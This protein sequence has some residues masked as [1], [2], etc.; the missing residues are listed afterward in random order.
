[1]CLDRKLKISWSKNGFIAYSDLTPTSNL[2]ITK[3]ESI[4]GSSWRLS[5]KK[6]YQIKTNPLSSLNPITNVYWSTS[7]MDLAII[8]DLGNLTIL[9]TGVLKTNSSHQLSCFEDVDIIYQDDVCERPLNT[10]QPKLLNSSQNGG[11]STTKVISFKWLNVDKPIISNSPA[12]R[13]HTTQESMVSSGAAADGAAASSDSSGYAYSYAVHQYKSYG[14]LHPIQGKSGFFAVRRNGEVDFYYQATVQGS[15]F[16]KTSVLL[17]DVDNI[18]SLWLKHADIGFNRDGSLIV[19]T[20]SPLVKALR[21]YQVKIDWGTVSSTTK[22]SPKLSVVKLVSE[23]LNIIGDNG[24]PQELNG[25]DIISPNFSLDTELEILLTFNGPGVVGGKTLLKKL[26]LSNEFKNLRFKN[27]GFNND[28][29]ITVE[30]YTNLASTGDILLQQEVL[31]ISFKNFEFIIAI[32]LAN[33]EIQLRNRKSL[34]LLGNKNNEPIPQSISTLLDAGYEFPLPGF[35]PDAVSISPNICG[36]VVY[37]PHDRLLKYHTTSRPTSNLVKGEVLT[38]SAAFGYKYSSACFTNLSSDDLIIAIQSEIFKIKDTQLKNQLILA[39]LEESHRALNFS[40]DHSKDQIDRLLVNPPIQKLLS[41]QYS[42]GKLTST[43]ETTLI[44]LSILNLRLVAFSLML[45][46]RTLFHHQQRVTKKGNESLMDSIYRSESVLSTLGTINWFMEFL[47]FTVQELINVV[48]SDDLQDKS[49]F[50]TIMLSLLLSKIPRSLMVYSIAGIKRIDGFLVKVQDLNNT[51]NPGSLNMEVLNKS[52]ER[53][54]HLLTLIDLDKFEKFLS[55]TE[56]L[57]HR[58]LDKSSALSIEQTLVF[59]NKIPSG[60]QVSI[61]AML[62]KFQELLQDSPNLS[63][64][65]FHDTRWLNLQIRTNKNPSKIFKG[66]EDKVPILFGTNETLIDDVTKVVIT[67]KEKLK[68]CLRCEY[69]TS[70]DTEGYFSS[71]IKGA[72]SNANLNHWPVAFH[73]TCLCGSCWVY[74]TP[75]EVSQGF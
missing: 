4:K 17:E 25:I 27:D 47:I 69:I 2:S 44:A 36:Y 54:K 66:P 49:H 22:L 59:Q 7:G 20:Y 18:N 38:L 6:I 1:M 8:D 45:S 43:N 63:E 72:S 19:A 13:V 37:N 41:L 71:S 55:D 60:Y 53:Y 67:N 9:S 64:L 46:L 75:N 10:K 33:G 57:F 30:N 16:Q 12:V 50:N 61:D 56:N 11:D 24:F 21:V 29:A 31:D 14:I 23:P 35:K 3:L 15:D 32:T 40:L 58:Q 62:N 42:L 28:S 26:Q 5:P 52:I 48:H 65:Y 51:S 68:K 70:N 34:N 74:I 73:R 39:I